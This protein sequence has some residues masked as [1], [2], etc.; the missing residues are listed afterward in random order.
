M[1]HMAVPSC[2]CARRHAGKTACIP[3]QAYALVA[4]NPTGIT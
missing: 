2:V 3:P 1:N 4:R